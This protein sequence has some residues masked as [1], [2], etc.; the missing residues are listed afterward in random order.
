MG[1]ISTR[2]RL[3]LW[4]AKLAGRRFPKE[5]DRPRPFVLLSKQRS[6]STWLMDLLDSHPQICVY[7]ELFHSGGYGRPRVGRNRDILFWKS[8]A[9]IHQPRGRL[10]K[11]RSYFEYLD[12]EVFCPQ[13]GIAAAGFKLMYNQAAT[14]L[15]VLAYLSVRGVSIIHLIRGNHL[16][17]VLSEETSSVRG[18]FHAEVGA[19]IDDLQIELDMFT[20][21]DR[22]KRREA[23]INAARRF[24]STARL[25]YH[26]VYY[27]D[28]LADPAALK[29]VLN[30]LHVRENPSLTSSLTKINSTNQQRLISNYGEI[31]ATLTGTRFAGL[32]R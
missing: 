20:L 26:E 32:L 18:M 14:E 25:P 1:I 11:L 6:G 7:G 9:A 10:A 5:D 30:F 4:F 27:E 24:F 31:K 12:A 29:P 2:A 13:P 16:D 17:A 28:L 21:L 8:Y 22:I 19:K 15:G 23:D 3:L